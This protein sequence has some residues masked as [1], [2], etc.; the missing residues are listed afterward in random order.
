VRLLLSLLV[1]CAAC[2]RPA[3]P[4]PAG[5]AADPLPA[6]IG[7][8]AGGPL[9]RDDA[10]T[11]RSYVRGTT[12]IE[13]TLA[14]FP[15]T[16]EQY[17]DWVRTSTEGYPQA[18]LDLPAGDANGFYQCRTD[19]PERCDLLVQLRAGFH[20]EI[21]GGGTSTRGDVDA[22]ARG[23]PLRALAARAI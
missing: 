18:T 9:L 22:I 11:R 7:D 5:S 15:M 23:L 13:V 10:A 12:H 3:A 21:R 6:R 4:S 2:R 17:R 8:F 14:R 16:A 20:V 19:D 1:A